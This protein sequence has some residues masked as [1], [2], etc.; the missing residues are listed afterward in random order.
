MIGAK[1][2]DHC[3]GGRAERRADLEGRA[4][5]RPTLENGRRGGRPS[6]HS[7]PA[8]AQGFR[9]HGGSGRFSAAAS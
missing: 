6:M 8:F 9:E 7:A 2:M 4:L 3:A 1:P 5:S